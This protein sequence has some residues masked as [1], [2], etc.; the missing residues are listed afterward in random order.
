M[1]PLAFKFRS[2]CQFY[3][4]IYIFQLCV[5]KIALAKTALGEG[6][7]Q[8]CKSRGSQVTRATEHC[9]LAASIRGPCSKILKFTLEQ[10]M[11]AQRVSRGITTLSLT[12]TLDWGEW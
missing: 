7:L 3:P 4:H 2:V 5:V 8:G 12:W 1:N 6:L 11:K 9:T 10:F